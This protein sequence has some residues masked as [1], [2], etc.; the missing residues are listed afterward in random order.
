MNKKELIDKVK[1]IV[2]EAEQMKK[3]YFWTPDSCAAG[4]RAYERRHS[5]GEV[6]W[7]DG[8]D[9]YTAEYI[10]D[11]SCKN[12]YARGVYTRNGEKTTLA[13]IKNSLK[14]LEA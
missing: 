6:E 4:R 11:C 9:I 14:R 1:A 3:A 10:V 8:K 13:A 5:H 12:I 7:L 2:E